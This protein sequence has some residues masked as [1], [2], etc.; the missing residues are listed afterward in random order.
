MGGESRRTS[1]QPWDE[2]NPRNGRQ[3]IVPCMILSHLPHAVVAHDDG[4]LLRVEDRAF[5]GEL[6]APLLELRKWEINEP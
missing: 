4:I 3:G 5:P 1:L 6:V 2:E